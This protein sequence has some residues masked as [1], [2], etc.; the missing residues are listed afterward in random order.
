MEYL[1]LLAFATTLSFGSDR[2]C[3]MY[4]C[5]SLKHCFIS[6]IMKSFPGKEIKYLGPYSRIQYDVSCSCMQA[7]KRKW[8]DGQMRPLSRMVPPIMRKNSC[9]CI[10]K[11]PK[12]V[13]PL[14]YLLNIN[15]NHLSIHAVLRFASIFIHQL[16]ALCI[17]SLL[18]SSI[19]LYY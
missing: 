1:L 17:H 7:N 18:H 9:F 16:H 12:V 10:N 11:D 14:L 6:E 8:E 4:D 15:A 2:S 19:P 13:L 3:M 5:K